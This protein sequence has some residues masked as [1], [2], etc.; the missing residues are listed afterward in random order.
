MNPRTER[1]LFGVLIGLAVA[2]LIV[3]A[4]FPE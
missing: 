4:F 3:G 2:L 1:I